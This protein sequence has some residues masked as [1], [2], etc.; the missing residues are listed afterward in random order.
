MSRATDAADHLQD[1]GYL[2]SASMTAAAEA[3]REC[4]LD[5]LVR[6]IAR[7]LG[8]KRYHTWN[9][10]KSERGFPDLVIAGKNGILF[11]ELKMEAKKPTPAQSAWLAALREAG[12][13]TGVW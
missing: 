5:E 9:S 3:M 11:R 2:V 10:Q 8:L 12:G 6:C 1:R 7:D 4:D 13:N